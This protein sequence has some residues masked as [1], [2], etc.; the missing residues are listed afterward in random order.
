MRL[1]AGVG[2]GGEEAERKAVHL[3]YPL[4]YYCGFPGKACWIS[5]LGHSN[6]WGWGLGG[7]QLHEPQ[8]VGEAGRGEGS[9]NKCVTVLEKR[10]HD[11]IWRK[12]GTGGDLPLTYLF[13]L[14]V[15]GWCVP[16]E[17]KYL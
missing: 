7:G 13:T 17:S 3:A 5:R 6:E 11:L 9:C 2:F 14:P 15:L 12:G 16:R 8:D 10:L 1:G 4:P